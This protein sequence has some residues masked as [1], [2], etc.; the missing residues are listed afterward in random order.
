MIVAFPCNQFGS[1]E[2]GT[3]EEIAAFA[4]KRGF[5]PPPAGIVM[6]KVNVNGKEASPVFDYL[7]VASGDDTIIVSAL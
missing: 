7:K 2:P 1:Q 3:A 6:A 4:A 5:P